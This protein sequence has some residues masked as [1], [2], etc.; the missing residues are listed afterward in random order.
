MKITTNQLQ[1]KSL[2]EFVRSNFEAVNYKIVD[3][4]C[5]GIYDSTKVIKLLERKIDKYKESG[6][7]KRYVPKWEEY[8][9]ILKGMK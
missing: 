1:D 4:N 7:L 2:K 6:H 8:V 3:N 9:C 5:Y